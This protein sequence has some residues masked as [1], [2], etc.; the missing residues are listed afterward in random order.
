MLRNK[1]GP[2]VDPSF[3]S[4]GD[5]FWARG[6]ET[7]T[8]A[9][10]PLRPMPPKIFYPAPPPKLKYRWD[11]AN[12]EI[13]LFIIASRQ[14]TRNPYSAR[15]SDRTVQPIHHAPSFLS[16]ISE[17]RRNSLTS[18]TSHLIGI[19]SGGIANE[20]G[21]PY[22]QRRETSSAP[23]GAQRRGS[24]ALL[25]YRNSG[26]PGYNGG[27]NGTSSM[28]PPPPFRVNIDEME[29]AAELIEALKLLDEHGDN[30][31]ADFNTMSSA[32][33]VNSV[34]INNLEGV[35]GSIFTVSEGNTK[36]S[37]AETVDPITVRPNTTGGGGCL[38]QYGNY[39]SLTNHT[40]IG[41]MGGSGYNRYMKPN[42]EALN[43]QLSS[44]GLPVYSMPGVHTAGVLSTV[45]NYHVVS[46]NLGNPMETILEDDSV[47]EDQFEKHGE[48]GKFK[49]RRGSSPSSSAVGT[50]VHVTG[51]VSKP[52][53]SIPRARRATSI[54]VTNTTLRTRSISIS[55]SMD[56]V[57]VSTP[58]TRAV[59]PFTPT[60][61]GSLPEGSA[62]TVDAAFIDSLVKK[63]EPTARRNSIV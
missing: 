31:T 6:P 39:V 19:G 37:E 56:H 32:E 13:P 18:T 52:V 8:Y 27:N 1:N 17:S 14:F 7:Q 54:S 28:P 50:S 3:Y 30:N 23:N 2:Y 25:T 15:P 4:A 46:S 41:L 62:T 24:S 57:V 33:S 5:P 34:E 61:P 53:R 55:S 21:T 47:D 22:H 20:Q 11:M 38:D 26:N 59:V 36:M 58:T 51:K 49:Q 12:G 44:F 35:S 48:N 43:Q 29:A 63:R 10:G 42:Q 45:Q 16:T 60:L 9:M 40:S